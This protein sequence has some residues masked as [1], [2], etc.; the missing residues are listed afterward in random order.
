MISQEIHYAGVNDHVIDLF[1]SQYR[2]PNGMAYNS[3]VITD[4]KN[5]V[6]DRWMPILP[7]RG[8]TTFGVCWRGRPP[9][10]SSFSTWSRITPAACSGS[11]RP[12][13]PRR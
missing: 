3:Y 12:I 1:E 4:E 13:P 6:I 5:A 7:R 2:V 11:W 9:I 8:W 10:I